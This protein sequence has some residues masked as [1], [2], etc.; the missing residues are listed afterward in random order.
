MLYSRKEIQ[1]TRIFPDLTGPRV[2][3]NHKG[4]KKDYKLSSAGSGKVYLF[5]FIQS[6]ELQ[7][8]YFPGTWKESSADDMNFRKIFLPLIMS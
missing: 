1:Q 4:L 8:Y 2:A 3:T 5:F 6:G 7:K